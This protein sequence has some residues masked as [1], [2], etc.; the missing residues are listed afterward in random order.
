MDLKRGAGQPVISRALKD[1]M[2]EWELKWVIQVK[3]DKISLCVF[4][5]QKNPTKMLNS[6]GNS[7]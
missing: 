6:L 7:P 1:I 2:G 5:R 4:I 3:K